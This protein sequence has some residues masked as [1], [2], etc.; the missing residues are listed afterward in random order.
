MII[1]VNEKKVLR[2]LAVAKT[3]SINEIAR[4]CHITAAGA[5][6]ILR[7]LEYEKVLKVVL[8]A[9]SKIYQLDFTSE[10]TARVLE[11]ALMDDNLGRIKARR[12]DFMPLKAVTKA[13][14]I[15][16]SYITAKE[17]PEDIDV[18]FIVESKIFHAYK[19]K[20]AEIQDITPIK[21]QDIVQTE[22][23]LIQ[24]MRKNDPIVI[25]AIRYGVVLWGFH[26]LVEVMQ[27]VL[28]T[29]EMS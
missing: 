1:T 14:I 11:L 17:K 22:N 13:S 7:K 24:N 9:N 10:K 29:K 20:L 5:L 6:K 4:E 3:K 2:L 19:K 12:E 28:E 26:T 18:L 23:D 21:I 25:K 8:I 15:F 16:G 27:H